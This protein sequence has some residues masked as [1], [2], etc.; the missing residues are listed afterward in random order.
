MSFAFDSCFRRAFGL[1]G[2]RH[3]AAT[4]LT[5]AG[6]AACTTP[7]PP[8]AVAPKEETQPAVHFSTAPSVGRLHVLHIG[9]SEAGILA[10]PV[11]GS[12][13]VARAST[14]LRALRKSVPGSITLHAGDV[15]IPA[16]E[17]QV[18]IGNKSAVALALGMLRLDV[19]GLGNHEFDLGESF[20]AEFMTTVPYPVVSS[21]VRVRSG[22]LKE[23]ADEGRFLDGTILCTGNVATA[24]CD[25]LRVG[26]VGTTPDEL[27]SLSRGAKSIDVD[28]GDEAIVARLNTTIA[29]LKQEGAT[30]IVLISHLQ[31]AQRELSLLKKGLRGVTAILSGGGEHILASR[32]NRLLP[33]DVPSS[34][35]P[36]PLVVDDVDGRAV[37]ILATA[38]GYRYVGQLVGEV[39]ANGHLVNI[40]PRS[41]PWPVDDDSLLELHEN[42]SRD[43]LRFE[44][45]VQTELAP[46]AV[47][48]VP[49]E[50]WLEGTR[51]RVR[52]AETNFGNLATDAIVHAAR[53]EGHEVDFAI[54]NAGSI[55][56]PIGRVLSDGDKVGKTITL[57]DVK[58]ALR[59]D[60]EMVVVE[61]S[62]AQLVDT[63][64]AA[65]RGVG[66]TRGHFLQLSK[67]MQLTYRPDGTD[68][69]QKNDNGRVV[70]V[71]CPG[72]RVWSLSV[73]RGKGSIVVV[74][75]GK[76]KTP[77][78][79]VQFATLRYAAEGGDGWFPGQNPKMIHLGAHEQR[80]LQEF[81]RELARNDQWKLGASYRDVEGRIVA[82]STG[83]P[84][85]TVPACAP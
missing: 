57:A 78:A 53:K 56:A 44:Q 29:R 52:N 31:S 61:T 82:V 65:L 60:S 14:L 83:L 17:L 39:D 75:E 37:A 1:A 74:E 80:A 38:G 58:S 13:G 12:G 8:A 54:R 23:L 5:V 4:L 77:K 46:L 73:P 42:P 10:D 45:S 67:G 43:G 21:T 72:T 33:G 70:G 3:W 15:L 40:D 50:T 26:I 76:L 6:I 25:G 27:V 62:H 34:L 81:L 63:I 11:R 24:G 48:I 19:A 49:N 71:Q 47:A 68:Q 35:G 28:V 16:P 84:A 9:D 18:E 66:N 79:R 51:E 85:L 36:Y 20:F 64:E 59:F 30:A 32:S 41:K 22:P 55:R 2:R 69:A 7:A